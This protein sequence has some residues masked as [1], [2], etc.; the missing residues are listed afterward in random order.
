MHVVAIVVASMHHLDV[1]FGYGGLL[2]KLFAQEV[3]YQREVAVEEPAYQA[4]CKHIA[5]F[6]YALV[7]HAAIGQA[8]F[9]HLCDGAGHHTVAVDVQLAQIVGGL[10]LSLL[11]VAL[12]KAVGVD[13]DGSLRFGM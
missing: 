8:L 11:Q 6:Q 5:T 9:Y 13:N 2:R 7:V 4:Q 3:F 10:K 1:V 12:L